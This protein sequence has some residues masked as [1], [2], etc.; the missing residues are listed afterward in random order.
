MFGS[1][2]FRKCSHV[3]FESDFF[4]FVLGID[5]PELESIQMG[6]NAFWFRIDSDNTTLE[7]RSTTVVT[8]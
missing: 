7:L 4:V 6:C 2:A 3:I 1:L 5:L 8:N